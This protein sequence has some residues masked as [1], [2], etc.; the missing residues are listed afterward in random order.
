[1]D[2]FQIREYLV[3]ECNLIYECKSCMSLFRSLA[4]F[5]SHKRTFCRMR[6]RD[7][8]HV[9]RFDGGFSEDNP[10]DEATVV[11]IAEEP[12]DTVVP[13]DFDLMDYCPSVELMKDLGILKEIQTRPLAP[14]VKTG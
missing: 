11:V 6:Y 12:V 13:S 1:M 7:R 9:P 4:N 10:S 3:H 2:F 5:I 8:R 14:H